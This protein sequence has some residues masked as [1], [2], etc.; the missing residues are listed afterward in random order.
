M[1]N[2]SDLVSVM[3]KSLLTL[4]LTAPSSAA[5]L[6]FVTVGEIIFL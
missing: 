4:C 6:F 1:V 2:E 3:T 5:Q